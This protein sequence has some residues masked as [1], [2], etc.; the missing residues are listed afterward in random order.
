MLASTAHWN[1]S[2]VFY[3]RLKPAE[4]AFFHGFVFDPPEMR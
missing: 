1:Y 3:N 4:R 2:Q